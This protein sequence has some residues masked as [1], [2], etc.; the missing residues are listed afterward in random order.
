MTNY[1]ERLRAALNRAD[2]PKHTQLQV[3]NQVFGPDAEDPLALQWQAL[4]AELQAHIN[5]VRSNTTKSH[6][7]IKELREEYFDVL[8]AINAEI[9]S[10]P[11]HHPIPEDK[12]RWQEWVDKEV[13]V[14]LSRRMRA[15]YA[16]HGIRGNQIVPFAPAKF[17]SDNLDRLARCEASI[18]SH[19]EIYDTTGIG[20]GTTPLAALMLC[21]CRQAEI[22]IKRY[23]KGLADGELHP[24]EDPAKPNWQQYCTPEMRQRVRKALNDEPIDM[25]GLLT[26]YQDPEVYHAA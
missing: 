9:R 18:A 11:T 13:R 25:E 8:K 23:K 20:R 10:Y 21:A 14:D 22:A 15:A 12:V 4:R 1:A 5:S 19:R 2:I 3:F 7:A 24:Y 16:A 17:R 26:F 6:R